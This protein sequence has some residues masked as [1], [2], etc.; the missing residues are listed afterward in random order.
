M[1]EKRAFQDI[2]NK[3][4]VEEGNESSSDSEGSEGDGNGNGNGND[5]EDG[6]VEGV[7]DTLDDSSYDEDV[8]ADLHDPPATAEEIADASM[9]DAFSPATAVLINA[10]QSV[11]PPTL[12]PN[13]PLTTGPGTLN[14][15]VGEDKIRSLAGNINASGNSTQDQNTS[16]ICTP[17]V[18]LSSRKKRGTLGPGLSKLLQI[19]KKKKYG[20]GNKSKGTDSILEIMKLN[21]ISKIAAESN[22]EARRV[23]EGCK[24]EIKLQ[25]E[26]EKVYAKEER[27][28]RAEQNRHEQLV[29]QG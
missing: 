16:A 17:V 13:I 27:L 28:M 22:Q 3:C 1:L 29:M 24:D 18:P 7:D 5:V 21:M 6:D 14:I 10:M 23:E 4:K 2:T 8:A 25:R 19:S 26:K 12:T 11:E 15:L 9:V 20:N